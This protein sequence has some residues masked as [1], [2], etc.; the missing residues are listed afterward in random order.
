MSIDS[1]IQDVVVQKEIKRLE[2]LQNA[3]NAV[4]DIEPYCNSPETKSWRQQ[5]LKKITQ[6]SAS[7]P[8]YYDAS[9][10]NDLDNALQ[11]DVEI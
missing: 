5:A 7:T 3:F 8:E 10:L 1:K 6:L 9:G 4:R 11:E 2:V